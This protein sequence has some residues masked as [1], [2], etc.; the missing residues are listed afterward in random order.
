MSGGS[1]KSGKDGSVA[2]GAEFLENFPVIDIGQRGKIHKTLQ[3]LFAI[4]KEKEHGDDNNEQRNNEISRAFYQHYRSR[5]EPIT[6]LLK[7]IEKKILESVII[8]ILGKI[9]SAQKLIRQSAGLNNTVNAMAIKKIYRLGI[10]CRRLLTGI[11]YQTNS[12]NNNQDNQKK[13]H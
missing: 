13:T 8:I 7:N 5:Q 11:N 9:N 12:W 10:G 1:D 2:D 3:H 4:N 6:Q